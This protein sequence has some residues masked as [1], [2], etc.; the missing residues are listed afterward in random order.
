MPVQSGR[1]ITD[2]TQGAF[3]RDS[4][5]EIEQIKREI[6]KQAPTPQAAGASPMTA[7]FV[8]SNTTAVVVGN[9]IQWSGWDVQDTS[10][11]TVSGGTTYP[12]LNVT[13]DARFF[14][15]AE[16]GFYGLGLNVSLNC[17]GTPAAAPEVFLNDTA[18]G[19]A[20]LAAW[21]RWFP[22]PLEQNL[23]LYYDLGPYYY[24]PTALTHPGFSVAVRIVGGFPGTP[25]GSVNAWITRLG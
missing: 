20:R 12:D 18:T 17:G 21:Q 7:A 4:R 3:N 11:P 13:T 6:V 5:K 10:L 16:E 15:P 22:Q 8:Y 2:T 23:D 25:S 9:T 19:S 1:V 14:G 24:S